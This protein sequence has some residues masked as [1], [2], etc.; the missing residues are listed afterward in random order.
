MHVFFV[1]GC[2]SSARLGFPPVNVDFPHY[3]GPSYYLLS[4][5]QYLFIFVSKTFRYI[6]VVGYMLQSCVMYHVH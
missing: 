4:P 2:L 5:A 1:E 3:E 6:S